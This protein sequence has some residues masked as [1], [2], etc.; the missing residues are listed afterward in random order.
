MQN[1]SQKSSLRPLLGREVNII[2]PLSQWSNSPK[3][4]Q[5]NGVKSW[6]YKKILLPQSSALPT[7]AALPPC[8]FSNNNNKLS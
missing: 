3:V 2:S 8:T 7:K 5:W 1:A 4:I 6:D